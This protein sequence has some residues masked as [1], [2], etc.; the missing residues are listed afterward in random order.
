MNDFSMKPS[1]SD[2]NPLANERDLLTE[3][4]AEQY[5]RNEI[6][7]V[8]ENIVASFIK[9][10]GLPGWRLLSNVWLS[11]DGSFECDL[12]LLTEYAVHTFEVKHYTGHFTYENGYCKLGRIKL[13]QDCIQQARKSYLRLLR[14]LR[15][16]DYNISVNGALIFSSSKNKV[17]IGS[18]VEDIH[19][20][21]LPDLYEHLESIKRDEKTVPA[22]PINHEAIIDFLKDY[23]IENPFLPEP[24][25]EER[26]LTARK[27]ICCAMCRSFDVEHSKY[28][29]ACTCGYNE[30]R[31]EAIV[32]T[33]CEY[34]VLTY[35]RNFKTGDIHDFIGKQ[36]SLSYSQRV[37]AKY[38]DGIYKSSHSFYKNPGKNYTI[39][40]KTFKFPNC[41][42]FYRKYTT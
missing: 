31:E 4:E 19:L 37:L 23:E 20:F 8:G 33:A 28:Y 29:I 15:Q 10:N 17:V 18:P 39:I 6:G 3:T 7:A 30:S 1:L 11:G 40:K 35:D 21:Q 38:F 13:E 41:A 14:L 9:E 5:R 2:F 27:G 34:G 12:L 24:I 26:I 42:Y 16:Y 36:A 32:R 22:D 25:S